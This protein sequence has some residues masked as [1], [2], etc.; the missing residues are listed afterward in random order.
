M[1]VLA[2]VLA[3]GAIIFLFI[4]GMV[5]ADDYRCRERWVSSGHAAR[6][7]YGCEVQVGEHW[8]PESSIKVP[9]NN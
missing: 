9:L 6:G 2:G 7:N 8:F 4:K 1:R 3:I 5:W